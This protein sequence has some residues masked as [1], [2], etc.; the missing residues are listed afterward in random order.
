MNPIDL[1]FQAFA[2]MT[3]GIITD[4]T[5]AV[6]GVVMLMMMVAG[7]NMLKRIL[8]GAK[9]DRYIKDRNLGHEYEK[10]KDRRIFEAKFK[11][12]FSDL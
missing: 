3:G 6:V 8:I 11:H 5:T 1:I 2:T 9:Y 12:E 10:Y 4:L 7:L